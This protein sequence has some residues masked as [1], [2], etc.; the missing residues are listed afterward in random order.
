MFGIL[1]TKLLVLVEHLSLESFVI[2]ASF[3]EEVVA[4]IPSPTVMMLSGSLAEVQGYTYAGLIT[5]ALLGAVG[6]TIGALLVYGVADKLEDLIVVRFGSYFDINREDIS[7]FGAKLTGKP[8]DYIVLTLLRSAPFIPSSV[9]SV[10]SGLLKVPLQ[11]YIVTTF[12][13]TIIRDSV[14]LYAG[15]LGL[16]IVKDLLPYFDYTETAIQVVAVLSVVTLMGFW[17]Y[18]K[19]KK[20]PTL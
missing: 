1:E 9:V 14:Y 11:L 5:L 8:R 6:K 4:P 18:R 2:V 16:Q 10:G 17:Y 15:Y 20:Q 7:R 13:G 19:K 12:I 3:I